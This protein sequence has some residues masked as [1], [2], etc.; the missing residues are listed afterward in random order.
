VKLSIQASGERVFRVGD[1]SRKAVDFDLH[2]EIAVS[3]VL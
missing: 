1:S 2:T 3:L